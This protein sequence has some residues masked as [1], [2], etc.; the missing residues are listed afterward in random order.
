[1]HYVVLFI[2]VLYI[3]IYLNN[4]FFPILILF[5]FFFFFKLVALYSIWCILNHAALYTVCTKK[6]F[7]HS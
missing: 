2:C 6:N 7:I 5:V 4:M 3:F 1:M